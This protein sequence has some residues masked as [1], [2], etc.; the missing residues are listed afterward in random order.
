MPIDVIYDNADSIDN[1]LIIVSARLALVPTNEGGRKSPILDK[2]RPNHNF[3]DADNRSMYIGQIEL[4]EGQSLAPGESRQVIVRFLN[5]RG[6]R[7]QLTVGR[8]WRI[9]EGMKLIGTAEVL[10]VENK[11]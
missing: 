5:V 1:E 4:G 6:L 10:S 7:E 2:L 9:Q 11:T 8:V 3:G